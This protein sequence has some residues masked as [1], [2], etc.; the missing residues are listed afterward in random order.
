MATS[1]WYP[2]SYWD[3]WQSASGAQVQDTGTK[4]DEY[5]FL[6]FLA[7]VQAYQIEILPIV[8]DTGRGIVGTGGT[9][10]IEQAVLTLDTSFAFKTYHRRNQCERQIFRTLINEVIVLSQEFTRQHDNI[11]QLQG[12]CWDIS[13]GDDRPWPVLVFEKSALGDLRRFAREEGRHLTIDERLWLCV[14]IAI[15]IMDMHS[16]RE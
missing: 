10:R 3:H 1:E 2:S 9:S 16:K 11:A 8:W 14:D 7:T 13:P 4:A 5:H 15:A 12:I 6:S